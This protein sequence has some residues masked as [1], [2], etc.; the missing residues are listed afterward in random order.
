MCVCVCVC[1]YI[2]EAH[3]NVLPFSLPLTE[4][5]ICFKRK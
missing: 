3:I 4:I 5:I 1:V 2:I